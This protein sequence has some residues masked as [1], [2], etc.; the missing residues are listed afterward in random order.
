[1]DGTCSTYKRNKKSNEKF[2]LEYL[3]ERDHLEEPGIEERIILK[4]TREEYVTET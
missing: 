1:M 4:L 3:Q 2:W